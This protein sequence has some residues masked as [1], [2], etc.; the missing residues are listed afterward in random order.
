MDDVR[1]VVPVNGG[2]EEGFGPEAVFRSY[3]NHALE[4]LGEL[5]VA[6]M[7]L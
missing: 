3:P 6:V 2:S 7:P 1:R 5:Y 4:I